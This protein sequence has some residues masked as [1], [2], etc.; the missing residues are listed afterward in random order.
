VFNR[1]VDRSAHGEGRRH[2]GQGRLVE[3]LKPVPFVIS[4]R[5]NQ[6]RARY[7]HDARKHGDRHVSA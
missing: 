4:I 5:W 3:A 7:E 1:V 2:R 6:D